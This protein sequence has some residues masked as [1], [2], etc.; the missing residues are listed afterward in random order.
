MALPQSKQQESS[1]SA[2]AQAGTAQAAQGIIQRLN[3]ITTRVRLCEERINHSKER[4]RVFDDQIIHDKKEVSK[5]IST[6]S[7][8]IMD[9]RKNIKNIEDT[10]H[11][12]IKELELTAK[13][14]EIN[15]IEKYVSM[16][17]PTR[18]ITKEEYENRK[19]K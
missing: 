11:H 3:E 4:L 18:Y 5:E 7:G 6:L 19:K 8:E 9:L 13:K 14:Q 16:M 10:I 17:D 2:P 12:I 15:I 1:K